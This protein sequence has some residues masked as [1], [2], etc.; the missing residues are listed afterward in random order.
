MSSFGAALLFLSLL[1]L[2]ERRT[3][4]HT[5]PAS[6]FRKCPRFC[7][8]RRQTSL[9]LLHVAWSAC[10]LR[11]ARPSLRYW[12]PAHLSM[13]HGAPC[14]PA[15]PPFRR[16]AH[17]T[18]LVLG[19]RFSLHGAS[20]YGGDNNRAQIMQHADNI[21]ACAALFRLNSGLNM[22]TDDN[23]LFPD[24]MCNYMAR[25]FRVCYCLSLMIRI[26]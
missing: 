25:S 19:T 10:A 7:C 17:N 5:C 8:S 20:G 9:S 2:V 1:L 14:M 22:L 23:I 13:L 6:C 24:M 18:F 4:H 26:G 16:E 11:A 15:S 21:F 3:N 12:S